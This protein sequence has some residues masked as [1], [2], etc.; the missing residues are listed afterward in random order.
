MSDV[1]V[2]VSDRAVISALNTPGGAVHEW[3]DDTAEKVTFAAI[4]RSPVGNPL[5]A[6]HSGG[7]VGTYKRS[8]GFDRVGSNQ[9]R[10]QFTVFNGAEHADI[11]E[12]GRRATSKDQYFAWSM[13]TPPGAARWYTRTGSRQGQHVLRDATN[14]VMSQ[15]V[16][17]YVPLT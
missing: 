11:V 9:H 13:A 16:S 2:D 12:F 6:L 8:W 10:L 14:R 1:Q 7:N 15:A 4:R 17:G 5:D 3:R